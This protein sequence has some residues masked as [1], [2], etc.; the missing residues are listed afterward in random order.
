MPCSPPFFEML[1]MR[2]PPRKSEPFRGLS[3]STPLEDSRRFRRGSLLRIWPSKPAKADN[4]SQPSVARVQSTT[5]MLAVI[6]LLPYVY[7][8]RNSNPAPSGVGSCRNLPHVPRALCPRGAGR[9]HRQFDR[10]RRALVGRA[11][12]VEHATNPFD[13]LAHPSE[14]EAAGVS[15][16]YSLGLAGGVEARPVV[17][18]VERHGVSHIGEGQ[19]HPARSPGVLAYVVQGFLG[20][21]E[22]RR[23]DLGR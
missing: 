23:L 16:P 18:Y 5:Q 20:H 12:D 10:Q 13:P 19:R 22:E 15:I 4:S 7:E 14:A 2:H 11:F 17:A 1:F 21:P 8:T 6:A 3:P 9:D